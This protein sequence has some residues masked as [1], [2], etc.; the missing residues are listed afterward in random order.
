MRR[1]VSVDESLHAMLTRAAKDSK[2]SISDIIAQSLNGM[3]P[4]REYNL[5][6]S[7]DFANKL[8]NICNELQINPSQYI[9]NTL[10]IDNH[11]SD[12]YDSFDLP[13][14]M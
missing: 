9:E 5:K 8:D 3:K 6:F 13:D 2:C 11:P 4:Y 14:F 10:N 12:S 1:L 7:I